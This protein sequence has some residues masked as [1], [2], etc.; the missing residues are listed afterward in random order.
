MMREKIEKMKTSS[1]YMIVTGIIFLIISLP[2][3]LDYHMF[4]RYNS[5]I[6]P[7]QIGSWVSFFFTFVG[8]ILLVMAFGQEDI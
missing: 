1:K 8:F 7:H 4:P 5:D 3:F 6:G 2:T